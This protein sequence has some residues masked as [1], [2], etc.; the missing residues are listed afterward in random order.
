VTKAAANDLKVQAFLT[1]ARNRDAR[2][3]VSAV[4]LA[5]VLRGGARDAASH[6]VLGR[7]VQESVTSGDGRRAGEL[8]GSSGLGDA[9]VDAV[10]AATALRQAG[11]VLI[12]TSDPGDLKRLTAE[13]RDITVIPV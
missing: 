2:V 3:V 13:R 7:V 10:V 5:E 11:P 4:T 9:T 12:L 8:L 6:R 1:S